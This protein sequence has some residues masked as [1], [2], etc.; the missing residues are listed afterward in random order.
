MHDERCPACGT[1]VPPRDEFCPGCHSRFRIAPARN[2]GG[3]LRIALTLAVAAYGVAM[4]VLMAQVLNPW[5]AFGT[6]LMALGLAV[7]WQRRRT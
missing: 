3:M 4:L 1:T 7:I 6:L 5:V 2:D